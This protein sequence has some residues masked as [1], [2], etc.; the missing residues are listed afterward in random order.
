VYL[1]NRPSPSPTIRA[2]TIWKP[3]DPAHRG[4]WKPVCPDEE[5]VLV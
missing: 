5:E 3:K 1:A 2:A 4:S